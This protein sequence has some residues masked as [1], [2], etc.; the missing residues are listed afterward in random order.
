MHLPGQTLHR[1]SWAILTA[2]PAVLLATLLLAPLRAEAEPR[3]LSASELIDEVN[4][5]RAANGMDPLIV[6]PVLMEVA[7]RQADYCVS[8]EELT[9]YGPDGSRPRDQAIAAGY[10]GGTTVFISENIAMG[11]GLGEGGAVEMW[12]G[13]EPHLNTMLGQYYRDVG[14]GVGSVG[15]ANYFVLITGYVAGGLSAHSTAPAPGSGSAGGPVF[16]PL[17][18]AT[19]Q[20]DGSIVHI[21]QEGQTLWTI[22]AIYGIDLDQLLSLNGMTQDALVHPGDRVLV[23]AAPTTTPS[24]APSATAS[25]SPGPPTPVSPTVPP[26]GVGAVLLDRAAAVNS[27]DLL[28]G[29][30]VAAWVIVVI[31]GLVIA[32]RRL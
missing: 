4:Q 22:A 14:A 15:D 16:Q 23:R 12:T 5:L 25:P 19:A 1:S 20:P 9:H 13:D 30:C 17:I 6:D 10:G 32:A 3:A 2:F 29:A 21:V 27:R 24:P 11:T 7:Q 28:A 31:A 18:T 26:P 8:I